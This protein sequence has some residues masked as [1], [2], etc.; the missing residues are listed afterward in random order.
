MYGVHTMLLYL[1][2]SVVFI[3]ETKAVEREKTFSPS[4]FDEDKVR[5]VDVLTD[6]DFYVT[7]SYTPESW[8]FCC[9][10]LFCAQ[11]QDETEQGE[12]THERQEEKEK[13]AQSSEASEMEEEDGDGDDLP[14]SISMFNSKNTCA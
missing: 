1:L 9:S 4:Y 14:L 7:E 6:S 11:D 2:T 12:T 13:D 5:I 3:Q 8:M 10:M